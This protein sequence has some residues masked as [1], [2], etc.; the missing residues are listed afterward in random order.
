MTLDELKMEL[1]A[2]LTCEADTQVDWESVQRLSQRT[3]TRL[4]EPGTSQE[5]PHEDVFGFLAGFN[6]RRVDPSFAE[7]QRLWLRTFLRARSD[8]AM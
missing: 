4:T 7:Q 3:Y 5:F 2:I 1:S 8:Q 6:R